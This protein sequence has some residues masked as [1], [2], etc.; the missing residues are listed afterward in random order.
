LGYR[1]F[2]SG[3]P[4]GE[5]SFSEPDFSRRRSLRFLAAAGQREE[6]LAV[7]SLGCE[8][9]AVGRLTPIGP[10]LVQIAAE[11]PCGRK[12]V[13]LYVFHGGEDPLATP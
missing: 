7:S 3:S 9:D 10:Y 2:G 11:V 12:P 6:Y 4:V 13:G 8:E 5:P 1:R